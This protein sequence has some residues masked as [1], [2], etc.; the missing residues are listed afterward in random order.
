MNQVRYFSKLIAFWLSYFLVN[1]IFFSVYHHREFLSFN[2]KEILRVWPNSLPLDLSFIGYL[3]A[4]FVLLLFINTLVKNK[5]VSHIISNLILGLNYL[6]IL[7]TS[8][9]VGSEISLYEEWSTKLNYTAISHLKNPSEVFSTAS[10]GNYITVFIALIL[11]GVFMMIYK[12]YVHQHFEVFNRSI[13]INSI[14]L[15]I[16]LGLLL[17][18]IRGGWGDVPL[19][20]SD[21]YFS[22]H[23]SYLMI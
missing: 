8:V 21:A 19:N 11:A 22:K 3:S 10:F 17:L 5:S 20:T 4:I 9:I 23:T 2:P 7:M 18:V 12:K 13:I 14:K 1:R 15:P 16:T 6:F